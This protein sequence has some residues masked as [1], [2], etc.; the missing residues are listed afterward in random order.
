MKIISFI[1][2]FSH[3]IQISLF[4]IYHHILFNGHHNF[5]SESSLFNGHGLEDRTRT[6]D[7]LHKLG[8]IQVKFQ[9]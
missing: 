4:P 9:I 3:T 8:E 5:Q 7:P 1:W 2:L 6:I